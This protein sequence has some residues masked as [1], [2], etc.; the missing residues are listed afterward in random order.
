MILVLAEHTNT[1]LHAATKHAVTAASQ[2]GG[3]VAVLVAGSGCDGAAKEAAALAGVSKVLVSDAPQYAHGLAEN[4]APL[5]ASL[6]KNYS[7]VVAT[8]TTTGKDVMPRAAALADASQVSEIV[9]VVSPDT[10]VRPIYAGNALE[11]VQ[12]SEKCVFITVRQTAFAP[13]GAGGSAAVET[14]AALP[15]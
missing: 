5:L 13:V 1:A 9:Q 8:A 10:F 3:E 11:T 4:V 6:A 14:V 2:I 15:D 12:C 7:H